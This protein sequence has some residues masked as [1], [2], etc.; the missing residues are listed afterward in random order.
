M[1]YASPYAKNTGVKASAVE[2]CKC[3]IG[4]IGF[5]CEVITNR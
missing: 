5:S 1:D 4:Y 2:I 3:P